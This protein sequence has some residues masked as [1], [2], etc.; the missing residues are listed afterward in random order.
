[1]WGKR[2][3]RWTPKLRRCATR[4][5]IGTTSI[6]PLLPRSGDGERHRFVAAGPCC[7]GAAR[8]PIWTFQGRVS[9]SGEG[10]WTAIASIEEG[11]PAHVLGAA[12]YERFSSRGEAD[13][14]D[15]IL[16]AMR[17]EFGGHLEKSAGLKEG[18][19]INCSLQGN[20]GSHMTFSNPNHRDGHL[21][22][23]R[24]PDL[25][26]T[27]PRPL[28][29]FSRHLP[30]HFAVIG[31]PA[32]S[33]KRTSSEREGA[34]VLPRGRSEDQIWRDSQPTICLI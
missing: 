2:S 25:A 17:Y 12:L 3:A 5:A 9:D 18:K 21:R 4:S 20:G 30:R 15:R 31:W 6:S 34:A 29:L 24:R 22:R 28:N 16:S 1:M 33:A 14:A 8:I 19:A 27:Y 11:V 7:S 32:R 23:R 13:F 10:R 26:Q